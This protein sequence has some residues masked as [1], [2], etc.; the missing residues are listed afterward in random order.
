MDVSAQPQVAAETSATPSSL[1]IT[2][3]LELESA[4]AEAVTLLIVVRAEPAYLGAVV[5]GHNLPVIV[6]VGEAEGMAKLMG[7]HP[8]EHAG[9]RDGVA[10]EGYTDDTGGRVGTADG[11]GSGGRST[12]NT[13]ATYF[14]A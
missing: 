1:T 2:P 9:T 5:G 4:E 6:A 14:P 12:R 10:H 7:S 3:I 13:H 8:G 11:G